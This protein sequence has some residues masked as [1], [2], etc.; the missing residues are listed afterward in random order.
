MAGLSINLQIANG[1]VD[2]VRQTLSL[3]AENVLEDV[4]TSGGASVQC[5]RSLRDNYP[6]SI[7][8]GNHTDGW[9]KSVAAAAS[10]A[11]CGNCAEQ[12]AVAIVYL[13]GHSSD[14]VDFM[15]FDPR[16]LD[17]MFVVI[18]RARNSDESRISTWGADAVIC[19]PWQPLVPGSYPN[20]SQANR[21][22]YPAREGMTRMPP[23]LPAGES[24]LMS[25]G[26]WVP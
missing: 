10:K 1:A 20:S 4:I 17:H 25:L 19:N 23:F 11:K 3:G 18:G 5:V 2:Y 6:D 7:T 9:I 8:S 12:C 21:R 13:W 22:A 15:A 16:F 24:H 14:S 26:R